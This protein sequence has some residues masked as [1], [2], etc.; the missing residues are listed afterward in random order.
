MKNLTFTLTLEEANIVMEGL[1]HL[2]FQKV[3]KVIEKI[4]LQA[5]QQL[6]GNAPGMPFVTKYKEDKNGDGH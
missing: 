2:P 1:G 6:S 3:F 5:N 4:H